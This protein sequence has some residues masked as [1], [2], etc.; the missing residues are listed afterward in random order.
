[1]P[2][3]ITHFWIFRETLQAL[4]A[5]GIVTSLRASNSWLE[6][7]LRADT[8]TLRSH[9]NYDTYAAHGLPASYGYFGSTG[10]DLFLIPDDSFDATGHIDGIEFSDAMHY[11]KTGSLVISNLDRIKRTLATNPNQAQTDR[12]HRLLAYWIGHITH[13]AADVMAH[14]LVNTMAGAYHTNPGRQFENSEGSNTVN[15]WKMHHR[16]EHY[17]DS[18][19]RRWFFDDRLHLPRNDWEMLAFPRTACDHIS[20]SNGNRFFV[21]ALERFYSY[22]ADT[23]YNTVGATEE[24]GKLGYFTDDAVASS[25]SFRNYFVNIIP[26]YEHMERDHDAQDRNDV[27]TVVQ[28][29]VFRDYVQQ[30]VRLAVAM[31]NEAL[32]FLDPQRT[33]QNANA[34]DARDLYQEKLQTFPLLRK[35]WN[36]DCGIGFAFQ[37]SPATATFQAQ[38]YTLHLPLIM[39]MVAKPV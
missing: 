28:P 13:I 17:Q 35:S 32:A 30:A 24:A 14:P 26:E 19:V 15:I 11:N 34:Q 31:V 25:V 2:G 38:G 5:Q 1:M 29:S 36:L 3:T 37:R 9:Y 23:L 21:Q 4:P 18:Y 10:P 33:Y 22:R 6:D 39:K 12:L 20:R 8:S 7:R 27:E 16:V